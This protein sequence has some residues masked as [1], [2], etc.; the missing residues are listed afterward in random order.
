VITLLIYF[1]VIVILLAVAYYAV[2]ALLPE[3]VQKFAMVVLV[4][5][6]ALAVV[7]LLLS[8]TGHSGGLGLPSM[9]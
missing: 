6:G 9:R 7:W 1:V 3:P 4:L 5:I 2:T 8:V